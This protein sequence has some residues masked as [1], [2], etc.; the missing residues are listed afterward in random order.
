MSYKRLALVVATLLI[1]AAV[2][3]AR[4]TFQDKRLETGS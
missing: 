4:S 1:T 2:S 3:A